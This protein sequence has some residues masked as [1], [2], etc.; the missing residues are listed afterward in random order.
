[1]ASFDLTREPWIP[2]ERTDGTSERVSLRAALG[3]AHAIR[4]VHAGSPLQTMALYRL[5]QALALRI[6]GAV[7][8]E[9]GEW[10][11]RYEQEGHF[12]AERIHAYFDRWQDERE[13]FD[14]FH[15]ERPFYQHLEP[16]TQQ[17]KTVANLFAGRAS[18][19]NATLFDHALDEEPDP[20][21]PA[22]AACGL[23]ATQAT[24][25][26]GGR[27]KPF[28][29]KNAPCASGAVFWIRG[30]NLFDALLLNTPPTAEARMKPGGAP[31]WERA[32]TL[33][34]LPEPEVRPEEGYLDY[35]TWQSRRILLG[36]TTGEDGEV[37]VDRV[38]ISQGD[39]R[40]DG[41]R[42]PMMAHDY[43]SRSGI[44]PLNLRK[45]RSLWRDANVIM[46][47]FSEETG[48]APRTVQWVSAHVPKARWWVDV[49]GMSNDQSKIERWRHLRM[50]V[51]SSILE[52][53][54]RQHA[55]QE[56]LERAEMQSDSLQGAA[57]EYAAFL[58]YDTSYDDLDLDSERRDARELARSS[59]ALRRY[60]SRLEDP[61][62][63]WLE[64]LARS[65][66]GLDVVEAKWT[67]R[68][69]IAAN[70]AYEEALGGLGE[71]A[72]HM[73]AQVAGKERLRPAAA[74]SEML[75]GQP[76]STS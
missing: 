10:A 8:N 24:A 26:A 23:V 20:V 43:S 6:E 13:A 25:L 7:P 62:F 73:R 45:E 5:L 65:D 66:E 12:E 18:G 54:V 30:Q 41:E 52:S 74:F 56:A 11:H 72:R 58:L 2:V 59:G 49:F 1:M 9:R 32:W 75:E 57:R 60:W 29:Y 35:L 19:N 38:K 22:E 76:S 33:D 34:E 47:V 4:K 16:M 51:Y 67:K 21:S 17:V 46:Q 44:Y 15:A 63:G 40:E 27:S 14:L 31:W 36:H 42:D 53:E 3:E 39:A 48:G 37:V 64:D 69:F 61:F 68:A 50:P 70:E 55:L 28:Y 71:S